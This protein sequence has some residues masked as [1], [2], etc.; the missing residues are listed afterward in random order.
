VPGTDLPALAQA[1]HS[2]PA[3]PDLLVRPDRGFVVQPCGYREQEV[4]RVIAPTIPSISSSA[5]TS[6]L[7][8]PNGCARRHP[9]RLAREE[10]EELEEPVRSRRSW[11]GA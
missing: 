1:H 9:E 6:T 8:E 5:S 4:P 7:A 10:P 3:G 2:D 11:C